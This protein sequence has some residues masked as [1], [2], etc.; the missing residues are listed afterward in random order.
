MVK[1][2]DSDAA[3]WP[4]RVKAIGSNYWRVVAEAQDLVAIAK[5]IG[6]KWLRGIRF[7]AT[8]ERIK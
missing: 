1:K 8:L 5:D 4:L 7:A 2:L 6:Q 3:R